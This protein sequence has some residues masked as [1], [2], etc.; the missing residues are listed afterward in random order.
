MFSGVHVVVADQNVDKLLVIIFPRKYWCNSDPAAHWVGPCQDSGET[1]ARPKQSSAAASSKKRKLSDNLNRPGCSNW[2][3]EDG[4]D[5]AGDG[6]DRGRDFGHLDAPDVD[7]NDEGCDVCIH[8]NDASFDKDNLR[9]L[10]DQEV[11]VAQF[12]ISYP[13]SVMCRKHYRKTFQGFKGLNK[14]C[15]NP[16]NLPQHQRRAARLKMLT[17]DELSD[18]KR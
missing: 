11:L 3:Y 8:E 1:G 16:L 7:I 9:K 5:Q 12:T 2:D 13:V 15:P 14:T 4:E 6:G 10:S 18:I 17:L